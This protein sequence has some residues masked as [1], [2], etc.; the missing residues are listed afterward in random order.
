LFVYHF[1]FLDII[2]NIKLIKF[3]LCKNLHPMQWSFLGFFFFRGG[4]VYWNQVVCP[5][6]CICSVF[7]AVK[8]YP[9]PLHSPYQTWAKDILID[10]GVKGQTYWAMK[11]QV[12][13]V[14]PYYSMT[15]GVPMEQRWSLLI[16]G[17]KVKNT[18]WENS[19][20]FSGL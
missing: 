2:W 18:G 1:L 19:K 11:F 5:F 8:C 12:L 20:M 3:I 7:Q 16:L 13:K 6:V 10:F 17:F 4:W 15:C 9:F 14:S